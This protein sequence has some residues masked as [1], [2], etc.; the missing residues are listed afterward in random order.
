MFALIAVAVVA[1]CNLS[2]GLVVVLKNRG[3]FTHTSFAI[4]AFIMAA[5]L[6]TSYYSND[7]HFSHQLL[8]WLNRATL[9]LPGMGLYFLLLFTLEFTRFQY[10]W[11]RPF[12]I[13]FGVLTLFISVLS[14]TPLLVTGI[15]RRGNVEAVMFGPLVP[16]FT[17]F[18]LSLFLSI[19][20]ILASSIARLHGSARARTKIMAA[21]LFT[22]LAITL[23]TNLVLP[24]M[25]NNYSYI[26]V[27]LLSTIIIVGG[28]SYAIVKH[29]LFD[30]RT[31][32]ARSLAYL[33]LLVTLGAGY[34]L[35]TFKVGQLLFT[36]TEISTPQQTFNV[37]TALV[38]ALT[39]QPLKH[40]FEKITDKIFFRDHYES[41]D[42]MNQV[43]H[44]LASEI[45][46][47]ELSRKV[48]RVLTKNMR[49]G[50]VDIVV[51]D[52]NRVFVETGQYVVSRLEDLARDLGE[53]RGKL[54]VTDE[55]PEGR[56]K[57]ILQ[58]YGISVLAALR[59]HEDKVGYLLFGE[60]L[61]GDI[62]SN[63]DLGV[64]PII[65]DQLAVAIQNAKGYVQIQQFN[66]TLQSKV[67]D[68]TKQLREANHSLEQLDE[69][70]D[71]FMSMASHQL[72]TPLTVVDGYLANILDGMYGNFNKEQSQAL[73]LVQNRVRLTSSLVTD[74]L[75]MSRMEA[76]RFFIDAKPV[77]FGQMVE[78]EIEQLKMKAE[79]FGASLHYSAPTK[80]LPLL[81]I[82]EQ[83]TRQAIMNLIDNAITYAPKGTVHI[84]LEAVGNQVMFTVTDSGI[85][86]PVADQAKLFHKFYRA[87]NAKKTK[88]DGT[89]IGLFLV[90]RVIQQEGGTIIF[91]SKIGEGSTFGFRLPVSHSAVETNR[92]GTKVKIHSQFKEDG[93]AVS[94]ASSAK[95]LGTV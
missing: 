23:G 39:F 58:N 6:I 67:T 77:D 62:Y 27:G 35:M 51:V 93:T 4:F 95:T 71:E 72:R 69:V 13:G 30:I 14:A 15:E 48:R 24:V 49:V 1:F 44:V 40:F 50:R 92:Q 82:D 19:V 73:A 10:K 32:V 91:T 42:L 18:I 8:F 75:N 54:L 20:I 70:K 84:K 65:A 22:S 36:H 52:N 94:A 7:I 87:G 85:G 66:K 74:L 81:N 2:L 31:I 55:E 26:Y 89:G 83:K 76:G 37:I 25:F 16:L 78:Q 17:L 43:S 3:N 53:L 11:F 34:S 79:E 12:A 28:F 90:K 46:L 86:V 45:Q 80:K 21:S 68:A 9:F 88:V 5:W 59:T 38:L 29:R 64:I 63:T 57:E 56:R 60:K 41:Q 61:N 47:V 33:L